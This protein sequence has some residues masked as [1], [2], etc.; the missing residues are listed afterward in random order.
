MLP[1]LRRHAA[2]RPSSVHPP[3]VLNESRVGGVGR[4]CVAIV[5]MKDGGGAEAN[6]ASCARL[7][8]AR[9]S[10]YRKE[11]GDVYGSTSLNMFPRESRLHAFR[12]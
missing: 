10:T 4:R 12:G 2:V 5:E 11:M 6:N 9:M 7:H 8:V 3:T 1:C